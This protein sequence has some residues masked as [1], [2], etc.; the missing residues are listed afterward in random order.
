MAGKINL[1]NARQAEMLTKPGRHS[2]GGNLYLS[3]SPNGVGRSSTASGPSERKWAW[4]APPRELYRL[5]RPVQRLRR[6]GGCLQ[7]GN[8]PLAAKEARKQA[9]RVI[10]SFG[11][12][13]D[14]YL[15]SHRAKFR[16]AKHIAQW[17]MTLT[18]DC[19]AIRGMP[20][21]AI[22]TEAVL[23]VLQPIWGTI[24]E[25]AARVRGRIENTLD[26]AKAMAS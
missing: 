10:P 23:K 13:A 17:Q 18:T 16:N 24:P 22:D 1:L 11:A 3:I 25:T 2:D 14:D 7:A 6:P 15:A 26:A 9:E 19:A 8:D 5:R 12:F 20:V 21:N 4:G